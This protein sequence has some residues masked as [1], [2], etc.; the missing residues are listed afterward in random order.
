[1]QDDLDVER[2]GSSVCIRISYL[3]IYEMCVGVLFLFSC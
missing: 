3:R 1:V 2:L